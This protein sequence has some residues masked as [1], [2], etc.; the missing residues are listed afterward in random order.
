[1]SPSYSWLKHN[2]N[3]KPAFSWSQHILPKCQLTFSKLCGVIHQKRELFITT[4]VGTS[5]PTHA[6]MS[7]DR[8]TAAEV[9]FMGCT[10]C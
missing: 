6:I 3:E 1:M 7:E 2:P 5:N 4:T 10:A 8:L 9:W